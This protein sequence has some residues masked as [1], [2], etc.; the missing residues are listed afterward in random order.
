MEEGEKKKKKEVSDGRGSSLSYRGEIGESARRV[1]TGRA[2][3]PNAVV[4][5]PS[6]LHNAL[7]IC[8][9]RRTC[10]RTRSTNRKPEVLISLD[11]CFSTVLAIKEPFEGCEPLHT[12]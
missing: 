2:A 5:R 7:L 1:F 10:T 3:N 9:H 4:N 8:L 6:R 12:I 11:Q